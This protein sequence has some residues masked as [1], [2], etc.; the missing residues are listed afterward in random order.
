MV[1]L[2]QSMGMRKMR[3]IAADAEADIVLAAT[4]RFLVIS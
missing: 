2:T 3:K 1:V 4:G